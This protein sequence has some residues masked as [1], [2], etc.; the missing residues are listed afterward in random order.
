MRTPLMQLDSHLIIHVCAS[1]IQQTR[2]A[3]AALQPRARAIYTMTVDGDPDV[4]LKYFIYDTA[5]PINIECIV[6]AGVTNE[7]P[8]KTT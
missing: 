3:A 6:V 1:K 8:D 7:T 2:P 4:L 5:C